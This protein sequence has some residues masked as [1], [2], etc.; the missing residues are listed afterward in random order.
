MPKGGKR[1]GA[2]RPVGAH[3]KATMD[4]KIAARKHGPAALKKLVDLMENGKNEQTQFSASKELLDRAYG[5]A[6]Q[7]LASDPENPLQVQVIE[8]RIVRPGA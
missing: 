3:N 6:T 5:K 1:A 7:P 4:V 8:R 2:G